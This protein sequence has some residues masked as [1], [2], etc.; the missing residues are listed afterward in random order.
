[1]RPTQPRQTT[2]TRHHSYGKG[3]SVTVP[4]DGVKF[5]IE[6]SNWCGPRMTAPRALQVPAACSR[7][8]FNPN[9]R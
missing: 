7:L 5:N 6:A 1:M 4:A 3:N 8:H 2:A 9:L